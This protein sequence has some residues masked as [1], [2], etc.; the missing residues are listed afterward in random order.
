MNDVPMHVHISEC[1]MNLHRFIL[2]ICFGEFHRMEIQALT[3][4]EIHIKAII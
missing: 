1:D 3:R 4:V 2:G